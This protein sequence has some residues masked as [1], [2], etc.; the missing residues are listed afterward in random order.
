MSIDP[1]VALWVKFFLTLLNLIAN[2]GISFAGLV[3]PQTAVAIGGGCQFAITIIGGVMSAF[4]SSAPG[5]L[6]PPDA[7]VVQ[8]ATKLATA[9]TNAEVN[10]AKTELNTEVA[11][12]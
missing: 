10:S 2:G 1:K 6:A 9:T 5:P 3:S 12:H 7:P 4:S 11:K 8:A